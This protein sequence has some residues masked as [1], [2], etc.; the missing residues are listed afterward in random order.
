MSG[1]GALPPEMEIANLEH[2]LA[3]LRERYSTMLSEAE[4]VRRVFKYGGSIALAALIV[5]VIYLGSRSSDAL[6]ILFVV[7]GLV[8]V[9]GVMV[10]LC[11]GWFPDD[12]KSGFYL[13]DERY[14]FR[15]DKEFLNH[16]IAIREQRLRELRT[17]T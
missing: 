15:T 4:K 6:P 12:Q 3:V 2:E 9:I 13:Y 5:A 1:H 8:T 7:A 17:T 10:W 14:P 11:T 16:A